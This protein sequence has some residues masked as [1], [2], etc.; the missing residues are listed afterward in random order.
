MSE[1]E[2]KKAKDLKKKLFYDPENG[3]DRISKDDRDSAF[4]MSR[5][6]S[7]FLDQCKT[8]TE[9]IDYVTRVA[10]KFGFRPFTRGMRLTSGD[11]I[12]TVNRSKSIVLAVIGK[13]SLS[14]GANLIGAHIDTP[15]IDVRTI[16]LYEDSGICLFKTHYYGG[17]KKYQWTSLPLELRGVIVKQDGT[18]IPVSIGSKPSDPVFT[19]TDLL[20]HLASDQMKKTLA[21]AFTGEGLNVIAGTIPSTSDKEGSERIKLAVLEHLYNS[22]GITEHDFI[23]ADLSFVPALSARDIG[24]DRSLIGAYGHDDRVCSYAAFQA[25]LKC[26]APEK[27]SVCLL[28]DK[29]ETGSDGTTGIQSQFFDTFM[30]D[31]CETQGVL[32]RECYERSACLSADVANGFDP[33]YPEVSEKRNDARINFG[34]VLTKY[35]GSRG[36]S[37]TSDAGADFVAKLRRLFDQYNVIWQTGQLG[38][39][40]QGGG[41]TIAKYLANRNIDTIDMGVPVLSMHAPFEIISKLDFYMAYR[42]FFEFYTHF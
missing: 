15:R 37:G 1:N 26:K 6:Y 30:A 35:T 4:S 27:T 34:A 16:P 25:I 13:N 9:C 21:D 10:D 23:S 24:F 22:L 32:P 33:N 3:Y 29:E 28:A 2:S 40:D 14:K 5:E 19:I 41:G 31:L 17:I 11:K 18:R 12:Y 7:S 36:K 20:P 42:A 38:K 8:E 39:V